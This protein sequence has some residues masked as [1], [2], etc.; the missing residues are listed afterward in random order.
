MERSPA[1][2]HVL[3]NVEILP[4]YNMSSVHIL[5]AVYSIKYINSSLSSMHGAWRVLVI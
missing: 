3:Q 1:K 5:A 2:F 4:L